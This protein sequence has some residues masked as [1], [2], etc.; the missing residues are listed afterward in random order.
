MIHSPAQVDSRAELDKEVEVGP[1]CVV[2]PGVK[3]K[4]G[5]KL[6]SHVVIEGNTEIGQDN[7]IH[8]FTV[9]GGMPQDLKYKGE[10]TRLIIGDRNTIRECVTMNL[11]TVQGGGLT[12]VGNENLIMAYCHLG[13]DCVV[14]N[15]TVLSNNVGLAGHVTVDDH[16]ILCGQT[17]VSQFCR[18][19]AYTY[20][21]GQSGIEKSVPPFTMAFGS[22]P[23]NVRGANIVGLKRRGFP[24]DTIQKVNEAVK[25]WMRQDV[26]KE[27]CL[28]EIESQ[29]GELGEVKQFLEFIRKSEGGVVR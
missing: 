3:I 5:T 18:V 1:W 23:C 26:N 6:R 16:A 2:G 22:R 29:Y 15:Q 11:G 13:H 4:R 7:I 21:G 20:I 25:L 24:V 17:G 9:L 27:Q 28:L 10:N 12:R 8:P 19:G 14:G